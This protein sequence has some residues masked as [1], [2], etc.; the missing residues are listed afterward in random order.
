MGNTGGSG[1]TGSTTTTLDLV[2]SSGVSL[3]GDVVTLTFEVRMDTTVTKI[4]VND[5]HY[6]IKLEGDI[7]SYQMLETA[8]FTFVMPSNGDLTIEF[9]QYWSEDIDASG[10]SGPSGDTGGHM[11]RRRRP[12]YQIENPSS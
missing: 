9:E 5:N 1:S 3:T 8:I 2:N 10:Q 4:K 6:K 12:K 7:Q 11:P